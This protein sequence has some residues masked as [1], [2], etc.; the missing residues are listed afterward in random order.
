[1]PNSASS[2]ISILG[3]GPAGLTAAITLAKKGVHVTLLDK[4]DFPREKICGDGLSGQVISE[5]RRLQPEWIKDLKDSG[6]ATPSMAAR[7]YS[8][9]LKMM[10]L[11][12]QNGDLSTPPGFI[13]KRKDFD[14][15]LLKKALSFKEIQFI[16]GVQITT[17]TRADERINLI[18]QQGQ[19]ISAARLVLFAGGSNKRLIRQLDADHQSVKPAGIGVRGYFQHVSGADEKHA[20]EIHFLKELLPWYLWI[21]PFGDGSANVG[22]A[23]PEELAGKQQVSLKELLFQ[24]IGSYP[25]LQERFKYAILQGKIEAGRLPYFT[26]STCV[27]GDQYLLLG[28]AGRLIDPFTGE[29]IGNAMASR[30][31]AAETAA[32]CFR[33]GNFS[34]DITGKY[35]QLIESRL[36]PELSLSLKLQKLARK[37]ALLNLVIGR[38]SRHEKTRKL[39]SS[40]LYDQ[41]VKMKLGRPGF[42]MKI[43]LGR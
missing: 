4:D 39:I 36:V 3:A 29:G 16:S 34:R 40:M 11:S 24:L 31:Y 17:L 41:D 8:P 13:C 6:L 7:F 19:T 35:Q 9:N 2:D 5:L 33:T 18:D 15:F 12:F 1:M 27:S 23:L 43:L 30:R 14:Q 28:D 20:I 37:P 38:A 25:Y 32:E 21:F 22:L 42:Y 10:E 26:G